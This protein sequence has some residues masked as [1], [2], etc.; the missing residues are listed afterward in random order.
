LIRKQKIEQLQE[1]SQHQIKNTWYKCHFNLANDRGIH[2][3][4]PSEMPHAMQLGIFKYSHDIFFDFI[5]NDAA[6]AQEINGLAK[7]YS[8]LIARQSERSL[9][10][11][12]F[13]KGIKDGKLMAKDYRGVLLIMAAVL[14][15]T[16]GRKMLSTKQ[17]FKKEARK[18][19][20]ILL[21]ELLLEWEAYLC[22]PMMKKAHVARLDKKHCY[23]MYITK[24]V[25]QRTKGVGSSEMA[26]GSV[27]PKKFVGDDGGDLTATTGKIWRYRSHKLTRTYAVASNKSWRSQ[28]NKVLMMVLPTRSTPN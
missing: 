24:K 14:V 8:K 1:I 6:I 22:Q 23:I 27:T 15:S 18:D 5:G 20:W 10:A 7:I 2:G 11:T 3:A 19:D 28:T 17:K 26:I 25:A 13:S 9:P 4:C 21:V 12:H 16:C